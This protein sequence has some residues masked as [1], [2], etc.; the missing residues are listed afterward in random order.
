MKLLTLNAFVVKVGFNGTARLQGT[1]CRCG[2][3]WAGHHKLGG[4]GAGTGHRLHVGDFRTAQAGSLCLAHSGTPQ[5]QQEAPPPHQQHEP[6][7]PQE[8]HRGAVQ[9]A[10]VAQMKPRG[11]HCGIP[12]AHHPAGGRRRCAGA[13]GVS[14]CHGCP[15]GGQSAAGDCALEQPSC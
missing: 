15:P 13:T 3:S 14:P 6:G 2:D 12:V 4:G 9:H 11:M 7:A 5:E 10:Q 1:C 8:P